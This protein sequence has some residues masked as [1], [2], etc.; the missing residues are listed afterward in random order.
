MSECF[1]CDKINIK[2]LNTAASY[3]G[4]RSGLYEETT[5]VNGKQSWTSVNGNAI[6]WS[7]SVGEWVIGSASG[8]GGNI[9]GL[10]SNDPSDPDSNCPHQVSKWNV[11]NGNAKDFVE[12]ASSDVSF[13]CYEL[14]GKKC[15]NRS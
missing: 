4:S 2:L 1:T 8:I 13:E 14:K 7:A 5:P 15:E 11:W 6:W 9:G 3:Q 12:V 10:F